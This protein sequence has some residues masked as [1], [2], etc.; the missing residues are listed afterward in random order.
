M[1]APQ[2]I[3]EQHSM[4]RSDGRGFSDESLYRGICD[5]RVAHVQH[6]TMSAGG[7]GVARGGTTVILSDT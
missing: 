4:R 3:L 5:R 1:Q 7:R 2:M 6:D